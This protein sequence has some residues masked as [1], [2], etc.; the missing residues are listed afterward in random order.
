[1]CTYDAQ[2]DTAA[3]QFGVQFM[4]H[5]GAREVDIR[6]GGEIADGD[7]KDGGSDFSNPVQDC[8]KDGVDIDV[9]QRRLGSKDDRVR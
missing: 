1:M 9:N 4:Q 2:R 3:D 6:R 5:A 8:L 7:T